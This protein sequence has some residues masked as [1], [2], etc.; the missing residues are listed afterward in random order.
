VCAGRGGG[1]REICQALLYYDRSCALGDVNK[2][3]ECEFLFKDKGLVGY[4]SMSSRFE[5]TLQIINNTESKHIP[6]Y[7]VIIISPYFHHN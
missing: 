6:Q 1:G 5:D 4:D 2:V 7:S 3:G